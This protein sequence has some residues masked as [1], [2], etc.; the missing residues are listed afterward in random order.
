M[1]NYK[2]NQYKIIVK[3]MNSSEMA[4]GNDKKN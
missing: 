2:I 1:T 3:N 4:E